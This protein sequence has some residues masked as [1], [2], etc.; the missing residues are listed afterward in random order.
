MTMAGSSGRPSEAYL[1]RALVEYGRICYER[2]LLRSNDG[3]L[4][5]RMDRGRILITPTGK[6]KGRMRTTEILR[7]DMHSK[8]PSRRSVLRPSSETPMH[9]EVY[10]QR[11]DVRAVIHAHPPFATALTVASLPFPDDILPEAALL[12]GHVPVTNYAIPSSTETAE[13]IRPWIR[14]HN[15]LLLRQHGA[16]TCGIDLEE[17]LLNMERLEHVSEVYWRAHA[18]GHV[19]RLSV[20]PRQGPTL[21]GRTRRKG[22]F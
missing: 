1:R 12:L 21:A 4:S 20:A 7:L 14:D 10:R 5:V 6:C 19:E 22:G 11:S 17:A 13:A 3:N 18:L 8:A 9:L 15:V 16:L 2:G